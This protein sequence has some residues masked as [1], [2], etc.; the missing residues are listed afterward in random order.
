MATGAP[1]CVKLLFYYQKLVPFVAKIA[2]FCFLWTSSGQNYTLN[3]VDATWKHENRPTSEN[4]LFAKEDSNRFYV[5]L[6]PD[7]VRI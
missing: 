6:F 4:T 1:L 7:A 5:Q 2:F 3:F